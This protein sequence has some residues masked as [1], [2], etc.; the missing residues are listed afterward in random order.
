MG[1]RASSPPPA[2]G[3]RIPSNQPR[4]CP[5]PRCTRTGR[6]LRP[7]MAAGYPSLGGGGADKQYP[8]PTFRQTPLACA[9]NSPAA[10]R[11][12][13]RRNDRWSPAPVTSK[14]FTRTAGRM[15][16]LSHPAQ[17]A[18]LPF[19]SLR[20]TSIASSSS[21]SHQNAMP[22]STS[23]SRVSTMAK[24]RFE[25]RQIRKVIRRARDKA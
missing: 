5:A 18:S 17:S 12:G 24:P 13:Q 19:C 4:R 11:G 23:T 15:Q 25:L 21:C 8:L 3:A 1:Q 2:A 10:R 22:L 6:Q 14:H 7:L 20:V 9:V 16:R